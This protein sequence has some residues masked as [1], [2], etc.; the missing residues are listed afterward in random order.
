V[1]FRYRESPLTQ[2]DDVAVAI[3]CGGEAYTDADGVRYAAD[4]FYA[5]GGSPGGPM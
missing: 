1:C 4:N 5:G 3:N 2:P